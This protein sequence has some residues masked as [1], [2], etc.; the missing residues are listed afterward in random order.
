MRSSEWVL[1]EEE[2]APGLGTRRARPVR[3]QQKAAGCKPGSGASPE[4]Y[5]ADPHLDL[6]LPPPDCEKINSFKPQSLWYSTPWYR[7]H[8]SNLSTTL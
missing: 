1:S 3:T 8:I 5:P 6:G 4:T 2:E 7:D